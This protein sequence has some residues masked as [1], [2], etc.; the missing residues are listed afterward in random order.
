[1]FLSSSELLQLVSPRMLGMRGLQEIALTGQFLP[2]DKSI[3]D[4]P[5]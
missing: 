4:I 2:K 5:L 3:V 1:M